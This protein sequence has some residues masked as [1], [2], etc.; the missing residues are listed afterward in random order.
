MGLGRPPTYPDLF[1]AIGRMAVD[2]MIVWPLDDT[3]KTRTGKS[4]MCMAAYNYG[5]NQGLRVRCMTHKSK[6]YIIRVK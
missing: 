1:E 4:R 5:F 2:T 6:L 3:S